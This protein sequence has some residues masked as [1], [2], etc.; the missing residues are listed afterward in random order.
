MKID[1]NVRGI[2]CLV[3]G[4]PGLTENITVFSIVGRYLEH[5]RIYRFGKGQDAALY[6]SSADFMT[7]N[8]ERRVEVA[9]PVLDP[10]VRPGCCTSSANCWTCESQGTHP[11][12]Q[13]PPRGRGQGLPFAAR[14]ISRWRTPTPMTRPSPMEGAR[15]NQGFW[16]AGK[17]GGRKSTDPLLYGNARETAKGK[18][19]AVFL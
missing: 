3:P 7:R 18:L 1:L 14:S 10:K 5:R 13:L 9:C 19:L 12:R 11:G 6:I 2:C 15:G 4:I 8:T 17:N 16:N